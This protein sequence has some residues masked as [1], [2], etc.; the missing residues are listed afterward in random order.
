MKLQ[1]QAQGFMTE[2]SKR[3]V[4]FY[5]Q[6]VQSRCLTPSRGR[7]A[8]TADVQSR[9]ALNLHESG[10]AFGSISQEILKLEERRGPELVKYKPKHE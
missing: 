4:V 3:E 5:N 7:R 2:L 9:G 1:I 8:V 10:K 6:T